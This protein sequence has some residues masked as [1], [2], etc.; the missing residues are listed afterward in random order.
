VS[1]DAGGATRAKGTANEDAALI[2]VDRGLFGVFD[3]LGS[4][5]DAG[6]AARF[7]AHAIRAAYRYRPAPDDRASERAFLTLV[8]RGAGALV[9]AATDDGLT[10]ASVV[11]VCEIEGEASALICNIGDSRVYRYDQRGGLHQ[12]TLDDSIFPAD[13][14]LQLHLGEVVEPS[15]FIESAYFQLRHV[16]S[17]ALGD[18]IAVPHL[19][20]V[21]L[22]IG[23]LLLA[24][25]DGVSDNLT[26]SEIRQLLGET[27]SG[28]GQLARR[29]VDAAWTRSLQTDHYR[30]KIDDITA[31]VAQ[32]GI[33]AQPTSSPA[34]A[35]S[36]GDR[37]TSPLDS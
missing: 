3:G 9:A 17:G 19:W 32:V 23:D 25:T 33:A 13:W 36:S 26:F 6:L 20:V 35:P 5:I 15:G 30:A 18:G 21:P 7:A 27:T 10:T 11:R 29:V 22:A 37:V 28:P 24:V 2:D 4:S 8:V 14:D 31:V 12:C 1:I 16:M 34:K